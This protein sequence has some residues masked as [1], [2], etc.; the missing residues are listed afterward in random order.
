MNKNVFLDGNIFID[1][2][3]HSR[4]SYQECYELIPYLLDNEYKIFTS[5]DLI[6]TIYYILSKIDRK[7]ALQDIQR[8]NKLCTIIEFGNNELSQTI[9]LMQK[10]EGFFDLEDAIQYQLALN[11]K[12]NIIISNDKKFY[13]PNIKLHTSR[14]FLKAIEDKLTYAR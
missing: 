5:C 10:D 13:S 6:T 1:S 2:N 8:L 3:D 12:C 11:S 4:K 14:S 7:K 9:K